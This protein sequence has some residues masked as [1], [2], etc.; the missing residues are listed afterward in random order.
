MLDW[1]VGAHIIVKRSGSLLGPDE[2]DGLSYFLGQREDHVLQNLHLVLR[3]GTHLHIRS[4][5][6]FFSSLLLEF[7]EKSTFPLLQQMM[8]TYLSCM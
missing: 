5:L 1:G 6:A 3:G 8:F 7:L 2:N 4:T